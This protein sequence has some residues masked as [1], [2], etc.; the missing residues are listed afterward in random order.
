MV[1]QRQ[2]FL[3]HVPLVRGAPREVEQPGSP[4]EVDRPEPNPV[5]EPEPPTIDAPPGPRVEPTPHPT[6][7]PALPGNPDLPPPPLTARA[8]A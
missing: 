6:K 4:D 2:R 7:P 5:R 3:R 8:A 1:V